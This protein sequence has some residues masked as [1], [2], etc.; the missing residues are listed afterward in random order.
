MPNQREIQALYKRER[1]KEADKRALRMARA[2]GAFYRVFANIYKDD[3]TI[4]PEVFRATHQ[5]RVENELKKLYV[6]SIRKF[7]TIAEQSII[8]RR[9]PKNFVYTIKSLQQNLVETWIS[10]FSLQK[11]NYI[12]NTSIEDLRNIL[13]AGIEEGLGE[14]EIASN[15]L[16]KARESQARAAT[17]ARTEVATASSWASQEVVKGLQDEEEDTFILKAWRP[18]LVETT[19]DAHAQM[20]G[21]P[22]IRIED[23]YFVNGE[24]MKHPHDANGSPGN[25][26]NCL[27][28]EV[29][30]QVN[31]QQYLNA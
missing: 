1:Q 21:S 29:Y 23:N 12:A 26:I 5:K 22:F 14:E 31:R 30:K 7:S 24:F 19:R 13:N 17:I 11:A 18:A 6:V 8:S 4:S 3:P 16:V 10:L 25:V 27:C 9:R 20:A 2:V 28:V 15:I